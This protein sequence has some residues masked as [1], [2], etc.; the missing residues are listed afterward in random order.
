MNQLV[1]DGDAS[2]NVNG[3][4]LENVEGSNEFVAFDTVVEKVIESG[5]I[6]T[7][8]QDGNASVLAQI[9]AFNATAS[10]EH[11]ITASMLRKSEDKNREAEA[12]IYAVQR[13]T[14][15]EAGYILGAVGGGKTGATIVSAWY[16]CSGK[17][18]KMKNIL[19][20][21]QYEKYSDTR[22]VWHGK[23]ITLEKSLQT[24]E[25]NERKLAIQKKEEAGVALTEDE[26]L[27]INPPKKSLGA[28][29]IKQAFAMWSQTQKD[30][31][32]SSFEMDMD[33]HWLQKQMRELMGQ[34]A[35]KSEMASEEYK[36]ILTKMKKDA[37]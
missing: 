4:A 36:K 17:A 24:H 3:D 27:F 19:T 9:I 5:K 25:D 33:V 1:K 13:R 14:E 8:D 20:T 26:D 12:T 6:G 10:D 34:V 31:D 30:P 7:K 23:M 28:Y 32:D 29:V 15:I 37:S 18:P 11:K 21:D 16:K 2:Q 22:N 35:T